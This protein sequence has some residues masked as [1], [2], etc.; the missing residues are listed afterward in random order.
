MKKLFFLS[1][2]TGSILSWIFFIFLTIFAFSPLGL[3]K[4]IDQYFLPSYSIEFS[5]LES[6]GNAL[7]R[8]LKFFNF[9]IFYNEKILLH[10]KELELGLSFKPQKYF[11]F[12]NINNISIRNGYFDHSNIQN[13]NSS[14]RFLI[15]F[16]EKITLS[17]EDFEFR[18][19][20]SVLE[21]NGN[22][23]GELS[24]S[25][26]GQLSFLHDDQLSTIAV[27][28]VEESYRFSINLYSFKWL[29]LIPA[30]SASPIKDL[31][32]QMNAFGELQNDR[33]IVR[34]SFDSNG[35]FLSSLLIKPNKGS[36]D[37]QSRKKIGILQLTEFLHPFV[38]EE[39]PIQINLEKKSLEIPRF[40]VSSQMIESEALKA[41]NLIVENFFISYDS[42]IPK[43]S[44][45]IKDLDLEDLYFDEIKNLSGNF[46]GHGNQI[47]FLV[48]S[49]ASILKNH[50]KDFMPV[51]F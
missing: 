42:F 46:S 11:Y 49:D 40:F 7:N 38:D 33:S 9:N 47:K 2:I 5:E 27:D 29:S 13:S 26:S 8:N 14:S 12:L 23:Y 32:F 15:N 16:D 3:I 1:V 17:F 20:D 48:N 18:R 34:G 31:A 50:N 41:S 25:F 30:F 36:F 45:F 28:A 51:S 44:G 37:Y 43:Y 24:R 22:L 6:T 10:S 39:H 35:L 21:I 4:S 19:D